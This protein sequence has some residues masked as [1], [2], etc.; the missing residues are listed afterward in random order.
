MTNK[1][2]VNC[3]HFREDSLLG[4]SECH[5]PQSI[6]EFVEPVYGT[7][8]RYYKNLWPRASRENLDS[9]G[10]EAVWYEQKVPSMGERIK[11]WWSSR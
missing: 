4:M 1:F 10:P 6:V 3:K 2:C 9:C 11:L 5:A 7:T 8:Q